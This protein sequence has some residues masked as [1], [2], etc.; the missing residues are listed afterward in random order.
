[1]TYVSVGGK[2]VAGSQHKQEEKAFV[3]KRCSVGCTGGVLV[4]VMVKG[5][6]Q[7]CTYYG[8]RGAPS[9]GLQS[10]LLLL[11]KVLTRP[12]CCAYHFPWLDND[13]RKG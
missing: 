10:R 9:Q 13:L 1:M 6:Y 7:S 4:M 12:S 2:V 5:R 3:R 11:P 8:E